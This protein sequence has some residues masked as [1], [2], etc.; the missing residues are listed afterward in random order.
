MFKSK[1][2]KFI[3]VGTAALIIVCLGLFAIGSYT[4]STPEGQSTSTARAAVRQETR[5]EETAVAIAAATEE[6]KPTNTAV[7]T[8]TPLPTEVPLPTRT[9]SPDASLQAI[10]ENALSSSN[11]DVERI[12]EAKTT[13]DVINIEWSINDNLSENLIRASAKLDTVEILEAI[14]T[15]GLEY[16]M[17]NLTGYFPLIDTFGNSEETPV[18]WL[19]YTKETVDK[20]NW[21]NFL[22]D[23]AYVVADSVNIHPVFEDQ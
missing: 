17:I 10:V 2:V 5:V 9:L 3:A 22:H 8:N 21:S 6:A 20:I 19:T 16:S 18:V 12:T 4:N 11:R 13:L 1:L 15:S 14:H 7:P 23:N